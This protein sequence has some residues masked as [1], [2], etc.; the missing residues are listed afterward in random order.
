MSSRNALPSK[1]G[2]GRHPKHL[3]LRQLSRHQGGIGKNAQAESCT[4][5]FRYY[6]LVAV[7]HYEFQLY[8]WISLKKCAQFGDQMQP[9]ERD[10]CANPQPPPPAFQH[11]GKLD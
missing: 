7:I 4:N 10:W 1:V 2:W 3:R 6:V 5:I 8:L 11:M 9:P